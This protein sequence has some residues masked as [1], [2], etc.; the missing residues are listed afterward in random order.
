[1]IEKFSLKGKSAVITGAGRG[2]GRGI[3]S[4][5]SKA[6]AELLIAART[7][8]EI[9]KTAEE[10]KKRGGRCIPLKVDITVPED[11]RRMKDKALSEFGK[12]DILVNNAG[13]AIVKPF[14][15]MPSL[16]T[17]MMEVVR[18][19]DKALKEDEWRRIFEVNIFGVLYCLKEIVPHM[20][21]RRK[22]KV[23]NVSSIEAE[24]PLPYHSI[25]SATKSALSMLTKALALEWA[26][27]NINVN[28]IGPGYVET[29]MTAHFFSNE[30]MR[31]IMLRQIPL[32]RFPDPEEIGYLA[33]FLASEA[34][35]YITGQTI[36]IDGGLTI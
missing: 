24:R 3:A 29:G 28:A 18:D 8:E 7:E 16:R 9:N 19:F 13:M 34:S 4:A 15:E 1:M 2:I 5:M 31:E 11:V 32:R 23:I 6:G 25:Y 14:V 27:Y 35:D 30:K 10:I 20:I 12:I 17:I 26:R 36:F 22:G 33:V 21:E